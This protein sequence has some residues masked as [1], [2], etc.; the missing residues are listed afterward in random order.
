[1]QQ[2]LIYIQIE[3]KRPFL[4]E[5]WQS[6]PAESF[7]W[8]AE[9]LVQRWWKP[10]QIRIILT[11]FF[12]LEKNKQKKGKQTNEVNNNKLKEETTTKKIP[13]RGFSLRRY[14]LRVSLTTYKDSHFWPLWLPVKMAWKT[15]T[16]YLVFSTCGWQHQGCRDGAVVRGLASNLCVPIR[17]PDLASF[18]LWVSSWLS[19]LLRGVF[20]RLHRFS[21]LLKNQHF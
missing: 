5:A 9:N 10:R 3:P 19:T 7:F 21:P 14:P 18:V 6:A 13:L 17:F 8:H 12:S 20:L 15:V 2:N 11:I 16:A 4:A 1:M